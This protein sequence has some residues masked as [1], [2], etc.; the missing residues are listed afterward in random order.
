MFH[1]P[2]FPPHFSPFFFLPGPFPYIFHD[3]F[4]TIIHFP[5]F[6][7]HYPPLPPIAPH[8]P[9]FPPIHPISPHFPP[10]SPHFPHFPPIPPHFPRFSPISPHFPPISPHFPPFPPIFPHFPPFSP[11]FP[12]FPPFPPIS[13]DFP[14]FPPIFPRFS[15]IAPHFPPFPHFSV[16]CRR[17]RLPRP[18]SI[19]AEATVVPLIG[20]TSAKMDCRACGWRVT[21]DFAH[22][23]PRTAT[24]FADTLC[25]TIR[26]LTVHRL[27][28][29]CWI[30]GWQCLRR[31]HPVNGDRPLLSPAPRAGVGRGLRASSVRGLDA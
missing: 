22:T 20:Q 13:P 25:G 17:R 19:T 27:N 12:H 5:P 18:A 31:G 15:P 9:P 28:T 11:I 4:V 1:F 3:A 21:I 26:S 30:Q 14:P 6:S 8:C 24:G 16:A 2:P 23:R 29:R 7:P 10:I